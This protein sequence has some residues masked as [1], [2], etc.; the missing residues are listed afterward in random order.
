MLWPDGKIP[1]NRN[2]FA[3]LAQTGINGLNAGCDTL[4]RLKVLIHINQ[5]FFR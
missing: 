5:G 3:E 1:E 2:N 4:N